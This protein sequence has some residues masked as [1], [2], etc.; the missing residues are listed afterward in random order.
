MSLI[1]ILDDIKDDVTNIEIANEHI[2]LNKDN[3]KTECR[4]INLKCEQLPSELKDKLYKFFN[5]VSIK[6]NVDKLSKVDKSIAIEVFT[7]LPNLNK[8]EE[9]KL[10]SS[11]SV[12][13]KEILS[14]ILNTK[15]D[16]TV[17]S[18]LIEK[19]NPIKLVA[20]E[21]KNNIEFVRDYLINFKDSVA[22]DYSRLVDNSPIVIINNTSINLLTINLKHIAY[23][24]VVLSYDKYDTNAILTKK[25]L[26]LLKDSTLSEYFKLESNLNYDD[27]SL[28]TLYMKLIDNINTIEYKINYINEFISLISKLNVD[29]TVNNN[30]LDIVEK[31]DNVVE[32]LTWFKI[33]YGIINTQNNFIEKIK[34]MLEFID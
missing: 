9:A 23:N 13:N 3:T 25:Y 32:Y 19:I 4:V 22:N 15:I 6:D 8:V 34:D 12:I 29:D 21:S 28:Q 5:L 17:I 26:S 11:P 7:M 16:Y 20:E 14:S 10:T 30:L 2:I 33:M 31:S 1:N 27:I 18:D 24:D